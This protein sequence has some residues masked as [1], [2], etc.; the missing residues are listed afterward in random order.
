MCA[1]FE[2]QKNGDEMEG[3]GIFSLDKQKKLI[4]IISF[5]RRESNNYLS[6]LINPKVMLY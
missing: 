1:D 4:F 3:L 6:R 5:F 2:T